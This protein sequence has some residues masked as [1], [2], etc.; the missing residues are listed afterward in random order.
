L[1][2]QHDLDLATVTPAEPGGIVSED[3][4]RR[5]LDQA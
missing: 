4:V 1:A 2:R 5:H 3:D